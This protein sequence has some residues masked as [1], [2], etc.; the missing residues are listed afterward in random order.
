MTTPL[1]WSKYTTALGSILSGEKC[2][3]KLSSLKGDEEWSRVLQAVEQ[4]YEQNFHTD[5]KW[6]TKV[7]GEG[8]R[9]YVVYRITFIRK[10]GMAR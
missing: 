4:W 8:G 2:D 1:D 5:P 9:Y 10:Q 3:H 6:R 7:E